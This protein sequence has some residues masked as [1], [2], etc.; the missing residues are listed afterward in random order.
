MRRILIFS[1]F[2]LFLFAVTGVGAETPS[3]EK[4]LDGVDKSRF[5]WDSA[6]LKVTIRTT[7]PNKATEEKH[8]LVMIGGRER[9]L[10]RFLD[11]ESKGQYLLMRQ[12]GMW[13]YFPNT[14]RA[15]RIT[16]LQRLTGN[17]SNGDIANLPFAGNYTPVLVGEDTIDNIPVWILDL[18]AKTSAASYPHI[19]LWIVKKTGLAMSAKYFMASGKLMKMVD[20]VRYENIKG[21]M[22][23]SALILK[24]PTRKNWVS[25]MVFSK[26]SPKSYPEYWFQKNYLARMKR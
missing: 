10:V 19:K 5:P 17:T 3:A 25:E 8:F 24:E 4:L 13:M 16:P 7:R 9:S 20:F 26:I 15:I 14:R 12:E 23:L 1:S 22:L 6:E 2:V 21:N 11:A 18:E